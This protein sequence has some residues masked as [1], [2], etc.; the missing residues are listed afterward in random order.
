[1]APSAEIANKILKEKGLYTS[2]VKEIK[3]KEIDEI[4]EGFGMATELSLKA[5]FDGIEI[6]GAN[7]YI[8]QQF[9]SP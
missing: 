3:N 4:I 5:G 7:N 9:Y 2:Q 1:M 8:I 6:H